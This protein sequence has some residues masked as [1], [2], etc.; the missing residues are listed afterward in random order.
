MA[1]LVSE[2]QDLPEPA[3][4]RQKRSPSPVQP[5]ANVTSNT[6]IGLMSGAQEM[7]LNLMISQRERESQAGI[8]C[9]VNESNPG[10]SGILKQ[11]YVRHVIFRNDY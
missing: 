8:L 7:A 9:Y 5:S 11:R 3:R 1:S 10:F 2:S 4:K 6:V